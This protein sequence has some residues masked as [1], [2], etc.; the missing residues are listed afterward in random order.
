M[1]VSKTGFR[2]AFGNALFLILL[3]IL[4]SPLARKACAA[5]GSISGAVSQSSDATPI[6]GVYVDAYDS[7]WNYVTS[8]YSNSSGNYSVTDLA[9]GNYYLQTYNTLG[10]VDKYYGSGSLR[11]NA[12]AQ[13]V[14]SHRQAARGA[15]NRSWFLNRAWHLA[16]VRDTECAGTGKLK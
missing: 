3:F 14:S 16:S 7:N 6:E 9:S 5:G 15:L 1:L 13:L 2:L 11:Q 12:A 4:A 10:F 8:G